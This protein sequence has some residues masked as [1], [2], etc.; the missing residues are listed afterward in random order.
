MAMHA[1]HLS[2]DYRSPRWKHEPQYWGLWRLYLSNVV[3][4]HGVPLTREMCSITDHTAARRHREV[5]DGGGTAASREQ[6]SD[7]APRRTSYYGGGAE[8]Q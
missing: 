7:Q 1:L 4:A 3:D 6:V 8:V 5:K 2:L